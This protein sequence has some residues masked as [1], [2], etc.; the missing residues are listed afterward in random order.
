MAVCWCW[1]IIHHLT[2]WPLCNPCTVEHLH[3]LLAAPRYLASNRM[4]RA[5]VHVPGCEH[6][7]APVEVPLRGRVPNW[8]LLVKHG[9]GSR[10]QM[11]HDML[12]CHL[13]TGRPV[14]RRLLHTHLAQPSAAASVP[15]PSV[16]VPPGWSS[17]QPPPWGWGESCARAA[18]PCIHHTKFTP[19]AGVSRPPP[20]PP[21]AAA[22]AAASR[23]T[24]TC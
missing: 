17:K 12:T 6:W 20:P 13:A 16:A 4:H 24:Q 15:Q 9:T 21:A 1:W 18:A 8:L 3:L 11:P 7:E 14:P 22:A 10:I 19:P 23:S 5:L 2:C